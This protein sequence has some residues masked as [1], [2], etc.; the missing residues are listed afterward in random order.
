ME[1]TTVWRHLSRSPVW[2]WMSPTRCVWEGGRGEEKQGGEGVIEWH[3]VIM[4]SIV[5]IVL[6]FTDTLRICYVM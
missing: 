5:C 6:L 1:S 3:V 2:M 4:S